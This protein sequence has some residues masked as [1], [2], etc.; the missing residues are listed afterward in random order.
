MAGDAS[1]MRKPMTLTQKIL[2]QRA[3]G[4]T[5]PWVDTGDIV[6]VRVDWTIAGE[7]AFGGMD[8]TFSLLGRPPLANRDRFFL[9]LD[10]TVDPVSLRSDP[11]TQKLVAVARE[12][13]RE[14]GIRHFNEA[15]E[16]ILH[17]R[18]YRDLVLPGDV[19]MGA[20]SHTT[21]HG[22]L[23]AFAIG[24]GGA[25]VTV[26]MTLGE[27]WIEVPE[28][29]VVE[30]V[31]Q[32]AF[33]I[34]GKD[35]V[36]CTIG[37]LGRNTVAMERTVEYRGDHVST[38][39]TDMRFA[40]ANMT[41]E[42]GGLN[43]IFEPD[44]IVA[45][46]IARRPA[47][48]LRGG[49]Y[50]RADPDAEYAGRYR[51]DLAAL[52][53]QVARPFSP[54]NVV[55]VEAE[56]GRA[57]HG[58]FIGACTTSEEELVMGGLVLEAAMQ[59]GHS[60]IATTNRLVVP[61]DLAI[62]RNLAA[63]GILALY[64]RAGFTVD[65]P[66][67]SMCL[68]VASRKAGKDEVWLSSQNRNYR[69]RMGEG[70]IAYLASAATVAASALDMSITDPRPF[71]SSAMR[72]RFERILGRADGRLPPAIV[73]REPTMAVADA[74]AEPG[75]EGP[76]RRIAEAKREPRITGRVQRFGDNIDTD[77]II[78]GEFNYLTDLQEIGKHCFHYVRPE[79]HA[80]AQEGRTIVVAGVGWGTGSSREQ[81]VWALQGA[82]V[83][84]IIARSFAF[85][86]KRN[87]VNEALAH[88]VVDDPDFYELAVEDV[89]VG[90]DVDAGEVEVAGRRFAARKPTALVRTLLDA[91]GL[92]GAIRRHGSAVF[93]G[94]RKGAP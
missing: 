77:A 60:P 62:Q 47:S 55:P 45:D 83:Q 88:L 41:A 58:V 39:S 3:L 59:A 32:P 87:L 65:P 19:V 6:K 27:S 10:H 80:R 9:A 90:V 66:G 22:G 11:R 50:F 25:D 61:G 18:F 86:H 48:G 79:F 75:A 44:E 37:E 89:P 2:A 73:V 42:F 54:D 5:R 14:T 94:P 49:T 24:L 15:N 92:V 64:E 4:L 34:S 91:G 69:N 13:A 72:E 33:G 31:G 85:I 23:G 63:A 56:A 20:D 12:F 57:L 16:T 26:A 21:S 36:L 30:Y 84:A 35:I 67:C 1:V 76:A 68:G 51:I 81:A 7:L 53:P 17:T 52:G 70:S 38:W 40:I 71:M 28:A 78:P 8:R 43:G 93:D 46:W 82:G 29:I 74:P